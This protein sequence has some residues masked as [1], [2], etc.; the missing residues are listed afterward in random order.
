MS[1]SNPVCQVRQSEAIIFSSVD[2]TVALSADGHLLPVLESHQPGKP[3]DRFAL[4]LSD[5]TDVVHLHPD[6]C[7]ADDAWVVQAGPCPESD[8]HLQW[9]GLISSR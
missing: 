8:V 1:R 2:L 4:H 7:F 3:T 9:V 6:R 5:V